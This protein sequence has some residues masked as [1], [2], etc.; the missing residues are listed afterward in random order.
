MVKVAVVTLIFLH[1]G[2]KVINIW[3]MLNHTGTSSE[4]LVLLLV[5]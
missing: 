1:G 4:R 2:L 5:G 3:W